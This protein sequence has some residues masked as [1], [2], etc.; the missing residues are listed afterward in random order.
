MSDTSIIPKDR[1]QFLAATAGFGAL[2]S[3]SPTAIAIAV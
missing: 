2:V 3:V 1:R